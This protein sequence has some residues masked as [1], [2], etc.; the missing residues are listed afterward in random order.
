MTAKTH[1]LRRMFS[2][3]LLVL[4]LINILPAQSFAEDVY[5]GEIQL[6]GS[7]SGT[8]SLDSSDLDLFNLKDIVPGDTWKGKLHV[9]NKGKAMMEFSILSIVSNLEDNTLYDELDLKIS[10]GAEEIY[11]GSYGAT[12]EPISGVY[13][14]PR[15]ET[16]TFDLVVSLPKSAGNNLLNKKMDSTWTFEAKYPRPSSPSPR[17][18]EYTVYYVDEDG[19]ELLESKTKKGAP[20][21]TVTEIAPAIADYTPDNTRKSLVLSDTKENK[22]VFVYSLNAADIPDI[23][24]EPEDPTPPVEPETPV[25]PTEPTETPITPSEP[26]VI[27]IGTPEPEGGSVKTGFDLSGSNSTVTTYLFMF[28]LCLICVAIIYFRIRAEK[29]R[30]EKNN[31]NAGRLK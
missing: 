29:K 26:N 24:V 3:F 20:G 15:G 5:E 10:I 18:V 11:S 6:T 30:V 9:N 1:P 4:L 27:V 2:L 17:K 31:S 19:N 12:Q 13:E 21:F 23:P 7:Y 28:F 22:I 14:I 8:F 16:I 25:E